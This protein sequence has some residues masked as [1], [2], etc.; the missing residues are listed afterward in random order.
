MVLRTAWR[1]VYPKVPFVE[2]HSPIGA[3]FSPAECFTGAN[4]SANR[5]AYPL[6]VAAALPWYAL[7]TQAGREKLLRS[8]LRAHGI[9]AF[10]PSYSRLTLWRARGDRVRIET[11]LFP[12]YL[13]ARFDAAE[14]LSTVRRMRGISQVLGPGNRPAA[15][16]DALISALRQATADPSRAMVTEYSA[17]Y[18]HGDRVT[19]TNGPLAGLTGVVDRTKGHRRL[20][21]TIDILQRACAVELRESE[22]LK[23]L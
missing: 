14:T 10:L 18:A 12:G 9:E 4:T 11:P 5:E 15:L 21:I 16:P 7:Y 17:S 1:V 20:I 22:V 19:V 3:A 6:D 8:Q 23:A 2:Y 13:F